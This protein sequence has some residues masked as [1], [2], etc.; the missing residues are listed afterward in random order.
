M[1]SSIC[2][3]EVKDVVPEFLMLLHGVIDSPDI[4]LNVSR[5]YLQGDPNVRKINAHITKKVAEKLLEIYKNDR[6]EFEKKWEHIGLFVK[7]GMMTDDKFLEKANSFF[8]MQDTKNEKF[9][10]LEEYK[11]KTEATQVNKDKKHIILYTTDPVK[12][13]PY[14]KE[15]TDRGYSVVRMETLVDAAFISNIELKWEN[16]QFIRVDA[17]IVD[18]LIDKQEDSTILLSDEQKEKLNQLFTAQIDSPDIKIELKGLST[19][20]QPVVITRNEMMRRMKDMASVNPSMS[21]YAQM[22]DELQLTVNANHPIYQS[23]YKKDLTK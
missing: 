10:T 13:D 3:D 22:P 12:Q 23:Y 1:Q 20:S 17:D 18:N 19:D 2:T 8:V 9:Y 11:Q 5:S 4:P 16:I 15:A 6:S 7:Y 21:W 14:I